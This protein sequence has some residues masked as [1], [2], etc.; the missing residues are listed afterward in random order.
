MTS[1]I[2]LA[3]T[4]F[5][6]LCQT[7]G[8][9][10]QR[11]A[12]RL[13]QSSWKLVADSPTLCRLEHVIPGCGRMMVNRHSKIFLFRDHYTGFIGEGILDACQWEFR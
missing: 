8:A 6:G 9:I 12:A 13:D 7:A 10:E 2:L 11:Y 4:L 3:C 1:R 5:L